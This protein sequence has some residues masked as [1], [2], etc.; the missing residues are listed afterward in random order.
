MLAIKRNKKLNIA[1][2]L[3]AIWLKPGI[4][5]IDIARELGLDK[6]T[7]T[8]IVN[9]LIEM[10]LVYPV[11]E[12]KAGPQGGRKPIKLNINKDF[13]CVVGV[14]IQP[15]SC[16]MIG[17]DLAGQIFISD[18]VPVDINIEKL[19]EIFIPIVEKFIKKI[20]RKKRKIIGIG[21][22]ISGIV[23]PFKGII[24]QSIP[25][26]ITSPYDFYNSIGEHFDFI[27]LVENDANCCAW[28]KLTSHRQADLRD[29]L[30]VLIKSRKGDL[31]EMKHSGP[32][33]GM[34]IV[35]DG[36]VHHGNTFSA[37]EFRSIKWRKGN[38]N[39]FSISNKASFEFETDFETRRILFAELS[40]H[41]ALFVN[42]FN[43][44]HVFIGGDVLPYQ[45]ELERLLNIEIQNNWAYSGEVQCSIQFSS[46]AHLSVAFGAASMLL[47]Q[48]FADK[49]MQGHEGLQL[50]LGIDLMVSSL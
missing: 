21:F 19:E 2:I 5:R 22:G 3:R 30:F 36:K 44:T 16:T 1:R 38:L 37:G 24:H 9:E 45:D 41:I 31:F 40:Q 27:N 28:G 25:L 49:E 34:G 17:A 50:P 47:N 18:I 35:I 10:G 48:L 13:A 29:F 20:E 14:E 42:T 11:A 39:Q 15:E 32:A 26:K 7:V 33:V 43:L 4:S 23:D 6:S 46:S 12:G 8:L